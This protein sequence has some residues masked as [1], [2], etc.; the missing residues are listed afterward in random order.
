MWVKLLSVHAF[1]GSNW[2]QF[3]LQLL[4]VV[5]GLDIFA[6]LQLI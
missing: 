2:H 1:F 4:Q 6:A 3:S 5:F